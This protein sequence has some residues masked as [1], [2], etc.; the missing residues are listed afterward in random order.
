LKKLLCIAASLFVLAFAS[1]QKLSQV[2]LSNYSSSIII[3]FLVDETVIVN[4]TPA[5]KII[6]WGI[7]NNLKSQY[8]NSQK[9]D[10]YMGREEYYPATDNETSR[11]KIKYI[12]RTAFTYYSA[13]ENE[14]WA[15]KLKSI[16][17]F[18]IDYYAAYEDKAI[19]GNIKNA[20]NVSFTYFTSFDNNAYNGKLK[21][22]GSTNITY[23]SSF[24]DK[25]I[26]GKIK[27]ID[28][29]P[30]EYYTSYDRPGYSGSLKSGY[31]TLLFNGIKYVLSN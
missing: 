20:G 1:A 29:Q 4:I 13:L 21:S 6:E 26:R 19:K 12:G 27:S 9:L 17:S 2:T 24:D 14:Q 3:S 15:G 22:V 31:R 23:Y 7:E 30:F 16:G 8:Y 5:G 11:G 28:K 18:L 10:K 25:A